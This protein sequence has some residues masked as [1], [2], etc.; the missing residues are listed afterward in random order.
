MA[1]VTTTTTCCLLRCLQVVLITTLV[2]P[3]I[4][5][6]DSTT[7]GDPLN[8]E[9]T[10][11]PTTPSA[12]SV[13]PS[14][15]DEAKIF[16]INI[17]TSV[18]TETV[19]TETSSQ[20]NFGGQ[21]ESESISPSTRE[22]RNLVHYS[23]TQP[24]S[25]FSESNDSLHL[26]TSTV[27]INVTPTSS[28]DGP[29]GVVTLV[30]PVIISKEVSNA[31]SSGS[32]SEYNF[33]SQVNYTT[34]QFFPSI[35]TPP[36]SSTLDSPSQSSIIITISTIR[37][38][39]AESSGVQVTQLE[40]SPPP[41]ITPLS[42]ATI[43]GTLDTFSNIPPSTR[44]PVI[45]SSSM[46]ETT[47][48]TTSTDA[49][50]HN[51]A[52]TNPES[53][54]KIES[55][56]SS[57]SSN[58]ES[59]ITGFIGE[60]EE[61]DSITSSG[62]EAHS[63]VTTTMNDISIP[64]PSL[65]S[66]ESD[67]QVL[68]TLR[69]ENVSSFSYVTSSSSPSSSSVHH[70]Q[71]VYTSSELTAS[72]SSLT[73]TVHSNRHSVTTLEPSPSQL[74]S[75]SSV[76]TIKSTTTPIISSSSAASTL[77]QDKFNSTPLSNKSKNVEDAK[78]VANFSTN[79]PSM[80]SNNNNSTTTASV[81]I[82]SSLSNADK[83]MVNDGHNLTDSSANGT[84]PL[85]CG[86]DSL[87]AGE[88]SSKFLVRTV[89][90]RGGST[91][92]SLN[93]TLLEER[94]GN[95]FTKAYRKQLNKLGLN[96]INSQHSRSPMNHHSKV[97]L[98]NIIWNNNS[99]SEIHVI[100]QVEQNGHPLVGD[101]IRS[102]LTHI[103]DQEM[104]DI[105]RA[106]VSLKAEPYASGIT[107][108]VPLSSAGLEINGILLPGNLG[109]LDWFSL[110]LVA[111]SLVVLIFCLA[112]SA[113]VFTRNR[114][115]SRDGRESGNIGGN[116]PYKGK[117][118]G[119]SVGG[120]GGRLGPKESFI[121]WRKVSAPSGKRPDA[122]HSS[123]TIDSNHEFEYLSFDTPDS[124]LNLPSSNSNSSSQKNNNKSNR[125]PAHCNQSRLNLAKE[126]VIQI[127]PL[128]GA[129]F[130]GE[131]ASSTSS[132]VEQS[133]L[134]NH[135]YKSHHINAPLKSSSRE[136][137]NRIGSDD[138]AS[139]PSPSYHRLSSELSSGVSESGGQS[140]NCIISSSQRDG[141]SSTSQLVQIQM[142]KQTESV[143]KAIKGELRRFHP[144]D[145]Q[146]SRDM[147]SSD[148]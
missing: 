79:F 93:S 142:N 106:N 36:P 104:S 41:F 132:L 71:P 11:G 54:K 99:Q 40:P 134:A 27:S 140:P 105:L 145:P 139:R 74:S 64:R 58:Y 53:N 23:S 141:S 113:F 21:G 60:V 65:T 89:L 43:T 57:S 147:D 75:S 96:K 108:L 4:S 120:G 30:T 135:G 33:G 76:S 125:L 103:S 38:S 128:D 63:Q 90:L 15:S 87:P 116:A 50:Q 133:S 49:V 52:Q 37:P 107:P 138:R 100:Y 121:N 97:K 80:N 88:S 94:L 123:G 122:S 3:S 44:E 129:V 146:S 86:N 1:L 115:S 35:P 46:I 98:W 7:Y 111:F 124:S 42:L 16:D 28:Q 51:S 48:T 131:V 8:L 22:S 78:S 5:N 126:K 102:I 25:V 70:P 95:A 13:Q 143:V 101:D 12:T 39:R 85:S 34:I 92:D 82:N 31:D 55:D 68:T 66:T 10:T 112:L 91:K 119:Y 67:T 83:P 130:G 61:K 32:I 62:T 109:R 72:S 19:I 69:P 56:S 26:T 6:C 114:R 136:M 2:H 127:G 17:T 14:S 77:R 20:I 45:V 137:S 18:V 73:T 144:L 117:D 9:I 118:Y 110:S 84:N 24:A 81:S 59:T 148:A 29:N 47:T